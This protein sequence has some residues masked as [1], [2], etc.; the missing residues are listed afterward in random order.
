MGTVVTAVRARKVT[1]VIAIA[2]AIAVAPTSASL[3]SADAS[4]VRSA[5]NLIGPTSATYGTGARLTGTVWHYGTSRRV[6]RAT[7]WLQRTSHGRAAWGNLRATVSSSTGTFGFTVVQASAYDYRAYYPGTAAYSASRSATTYPSVR[8]RIAFDSIRTVVPDVPNSNLGT[9]QAT[10][11][12]YPTPP[13][14]TVVWLQAYDPAAKV[15]RNQLYGRVTSGNAVTIR[16]NVVGSSSTYRLATAQR[17]SYA[18]GYSAQVTY[19]HAVQRGMFTRPIGRSG[20]VASTPTPGYYVTT[21]AENPLRD[22]ANLWSR[23]GGE[24]WIEVD[25]TGCSRVDADVVNVTNQLPGPTDLRVSVLRA[26]GTSV[27]TSYPLAPGAAR[28]LSV[29]TGG[30]VRLRLQLEIPTSGGTPAATW[31]VTGR[32]ATS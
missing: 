8:Q 25:T 14:N 11:R 31:S 22:W 7:V 17:S 26:G 24:S 28:R 32:C 27:V 13:R 12:V 3:P 30:A 19:A 9:L 15:W 16:G 6:A 23:A 4:S 20:G 18:A 10:A 21:A 5:V 2:A 29:T 1:V